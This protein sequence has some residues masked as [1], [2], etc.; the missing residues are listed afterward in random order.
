MSTK[1]NQPGK[2]LAMFALVLAS[3]AS[4]AFGAETPLAP[5][6]QAALFLTETNASP[7]YWR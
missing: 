4:A 7:N 5:P 2:G 6:G 1:N 3:V